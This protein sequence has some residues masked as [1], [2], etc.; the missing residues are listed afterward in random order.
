MKTV[1]VINHMTKDILVHAPGCRDI[2]KDLKRANS[3]WK[4]EV[5]E[6]KTIAQAVVDDL[7]ESFGWTPEDD[8]PAPWKEHNVTL[9]PCAHK[10]EK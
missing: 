3:D 1:H 6:G 7:N 5:P 9:L 2:S 10:L 8:E 4:V